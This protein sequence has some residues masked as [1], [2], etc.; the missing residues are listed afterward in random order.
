LSDTRTAPSVS[1]GLARAAVVGLSLLGIG[2][3]CLTLPTFLNE[4][5]IGQYAARIVR[6][7]TFEVEKLDDQLR[8]FHAGT[9]LTECSPSARNAA[10][11]EIARLR[12][13][14]EKSAAP[15]I[16]LEAGRRSALAGLAC[17]PSDAYLWFALFQIESLQ[18]GLRS[19]FL[20]HLAMSYK[21]GA[22]E[23]WIAVS[24]NRA[25][26]AIFPALTEELKTRVLDEFGLLLSTE[27]YVPA[28]EI[29]LGPAQPYHDVLVK[30]MESVPLRNRQLL[31]V[32]LARMVI[33]AQ[34]PGTSVVVRKRL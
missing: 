31:A 25:A 23:A 8:R 34:I 15:D 2:W 29:F 5:R 3:A 28:A 10:V 13:R 27:L 6:G 24:R 21:V 4:Y 22:N 16:E 1:Q 18:S 19:E 7:D 14:F 17:L 32:M 26:F 12:G 30:R 20:S 33:D 11:V 9:H